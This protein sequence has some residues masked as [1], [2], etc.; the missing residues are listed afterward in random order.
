MLK[1]ICTK[2]LFFLFATACIGLFV[3]LI[4]PFNLVMAE[5]PQLEI[6]YP[7]LATGARITYQSDLTEYLKYVF[8]FGIFIGFFFV[9]LSSIWAGVLYFLS[10]AIPSMLADA[11]DRIS[12]AIS[13][14]LILALL[15]LIITTINPYLAIFKL[16][17]L[18]PIPPP[19]VNT[20]YPGV[21][22]YKSK[23][24]SGTPESHT[25]SVSDLGDLKNNVNSIGIVQ[26]PATDTY[27]MP[28]IYDI[29]NFWGKCDQLNPNT[30][31][32]PVENF[33]ASATIHKYDFFPKGDG[34]YIYRK[35]FDQVSGKEKNKEGG[36]LKISN[37]QIKNTGSASGYIGTLKELKFT[38]T[39]TNYNNLEDCTVPEDEQD[40]VKYNEKGKCIQK[41]CP[42]LNS[43]NIS[44]IYISGNYLV[45]LVYFKPGD[46][47]LG[48][49]TYCQAYVSSED[50]NKDG[51]QQIKWDAIRNRGQN[52][53][54]IFIM[55][56]KEK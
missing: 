49:W 31:C 47:P 20:E 3:F 27:Y 9:V 48:P 25:T 46:K 7:E 32:S 8:D 54:Y 52:P 29:T 10:P 2:L 17:K 51:P 11:K 44:S 26:D 30:K 56:I 55:P 19:E 36:Y 1:K 35:S 24:C 18:E 13:G 43:E 21:N 22:F 53:N 28:I 40:C 41:E 12:G 37:L 16:N 34:V 14:L 15:Y 6:D 45:L 39:S 38:G 4:F 5:E 42:R 50:A 33:T 23:D